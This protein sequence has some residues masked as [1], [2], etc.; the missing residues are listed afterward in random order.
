MRHDEFLEKIYHLKNI[1]RYSSRNVIRYE[2]VAEH[3]FFVALIA[4]H[5]CDEYNVDD[6]TKLK[7][8]IKSILHDMPETEL[9]DITHDV[10]EMLNLR[11]LLFSYESDYYKREFPMY[12]ELMN[13]TDDLSQAIVD[14]ADSLSVKQYTDNEIQLGNNTNDI[15]VINLEVKQRCEKLKKIMLE[16]LNNGSI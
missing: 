8:L 1:N 14:Y 5:I 10:K 15:F 16:R 7:V 12:S 4:L 13:T 6:K 11:Q 3:S 9:N 2:T